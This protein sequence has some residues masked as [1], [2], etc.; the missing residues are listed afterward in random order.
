M[1]DVV[2]RDKYTRRV[3]RL[4]PEE[5]L[6]TI[7]FTP[8]GGQEVARELANAGLTIRLAATSSTATF[9]SVEGLDSEQFGGHSLAALPQ[10]VGWSSVFKDREGG[11][12]YVV[13]GQLDIQFV[14]GIIQARALG[15][16]R[17]LGS[18]VIS[19]GGTPG[20]YS[21]SL[22]PGKGLSE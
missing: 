9:V 2:Y 17:E 22:P 19:E 5:K 14:D 16:I 21:V 20:F 13:P 1:P 18:R 8:G 4:K 6:V 15:L 7:S 11:R 12:H 10:V 3:I